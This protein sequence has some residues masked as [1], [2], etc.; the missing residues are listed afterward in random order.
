M[1]VYKTPIDDMN[2]IC[3]SLLDIDSTYSALPG[4][5]EFNSELRS[6]I[7]DEA[8]KLAEN[9]YLPLNASGDA[10]GCQYDSDSKEVTV[11]KGFSDAYK[12]FREG[13]WSSLSSPVDYGG[14]GLPF[15]LKTM[16]DEMF[17]STNTALSM[18][19][20]LTNGAIE[21]LDHYG[22][23]DL[24][25]RYLGKLIS[26]EFT[27]TMC[28]TEAHCGSD[29]GLMK[30]KAVP[31]GDSD[32][33]LLNGAKIWI[34][35]GEHTMSDNIIHLVLARL[36]DAPEG[37][38]GISLFVVPKF[39]EDGTRNPIFCTG[40]EHKMGINGSATCFISMEDAKGWLVGEPHKGL[41]YMFVMM[42][43]ARLMV[44]MQGLGLAETAYQTSL[45][46]AKERL[47]GKELGN[48]GGDGPVCILKHPDVRRMALSQKAF[49]EGG[50]AFAY[51]VA[52]HHDVAHT[53]E[54]NETKERANRLVELMTPVVKAYLTDQGYTSC[55]TAVQ[56]MGGSGYTQDWGVEQLLRDC[57]IARIYEGTNAIQALDLVGRKLPA[58][59]GKGIMEFIAT[60]N[61]YATE[62]SHEASKEALQLAA[63]AVQK[64]LMWLSQQGLQDPAQAGASA[65]PFLRLV[66]IAVLA[67]M[68]ARMGDV[69]EKKIASGDTSPLLQEKVKTRDFFLDQMFPEI[70]LMAAIV[71]KGKTT[72]MAHSEDEL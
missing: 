33:Y 51:W 40:L 24:K 54:D 49:V 1:T 53:A 12:Q 22:S 13:G 25:Q 28:L 35:G 61:Q 10:E 21:A 17:A 68:W 58:N 36:P 16:L 56:L 72:L 42:N 37:S 57:R 59:G 34:T 38:K 39:L 9:V 20:G 18:Y 30:T 6:A 46:F 60:L 66:G 62:C 41:K 45:S 65:T 50:R 48:Q 26:G 11:P 52:V 64:S 29:L 44:G 47:Q 14:Q 2:F 67:L 55:D 5:D 7:L 4:F 43:S 69:A 71:E 70:D 32:I 31:E 63:K 15:L 23:D 27:G 3:D 8:A 19:S